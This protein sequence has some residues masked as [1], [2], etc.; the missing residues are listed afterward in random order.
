MTTKRRAIDRGHRRARM[1]P[2][3]R[4]KAERLLQLSQDH[5]AAIRGGP[6]DFYT[7]G[8]HEELVALGP[9]VRMALGIKPWDDQ[10]RLLRE[11]LGIDGD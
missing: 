4:A 1:T 6:Q 11:A 7:D 2:E 8:R 10:E 5:L 3:L 9:E